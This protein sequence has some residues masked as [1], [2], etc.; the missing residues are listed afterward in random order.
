MTIPIICAVK[1]AVDIPFCL[2]TYFQQSNFML[3]VSGVYL[4]LVFGKGWTAPT[5]LMLKTTVDP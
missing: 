4:Q 1:A 3:S 5:I 2:M